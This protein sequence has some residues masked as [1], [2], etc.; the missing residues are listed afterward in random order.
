LKIGTQSALP[1]LQE[2]C[3]GE[4]SDSLVHVIT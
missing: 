1:L 4:G 3:T 2:A